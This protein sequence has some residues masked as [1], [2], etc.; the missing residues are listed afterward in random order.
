MK[1]LGYKY[2]CSEEKTCMCSAFQEIDI[3]YICSY[4]VRVAIAWI[5][6]QLSNVYEIGCGLVN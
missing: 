1:K 2:A 6:F 5:E 3:S 4:F